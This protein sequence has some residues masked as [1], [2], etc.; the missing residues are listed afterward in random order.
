M[1]TLFLV[2]IGLFG[3]FLLGSTTANAADEELV[4]LDWSAYNDPGFY[5][6][7]I[8]QHGDEPTF[9]FF[10]EEEEAFQ[11]LRIGFEADISHPCS[12]SVSKWHEA[13][14]LDPLQIDRIERWDQV[15]ETMKEAFKIDGEYYLLPADWGTTALAYRADLVPDEDVQSLQVFVDPNMPEKFPSRI[16]LTTP[17]PWL[18]WQLAYLTGQRLPSR[19]LK[20]PRLVEGSPQEC[21]GLLAGWC[22]AVTTHGQWRSIDSL[23]LE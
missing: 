7:Y 17:M 3:G 18:I 21:Q 20:Q 19:I 4:I 2:S 9:S 1:R 12:Q 23:G 11:K 14:L 6:G 5:Q 22:G 10:G 8:E 13:G 16:M 15:N